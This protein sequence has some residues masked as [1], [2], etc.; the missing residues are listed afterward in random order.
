MPTYAGRAVIEELIASDGK[1]AGYPDAFAIYELRVE[2]TGEILFAVR[3]GLDDVDPSTRSYVGDHLI[4]WTRDQ[5]QIEP[6]GQ[7]GD[8]PVPGDVV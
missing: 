5:G 4:L 6:I 1:R 3:Y 7:L 8:T 2:G